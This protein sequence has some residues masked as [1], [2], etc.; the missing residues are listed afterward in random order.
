MQI[1]WENPLEK[2]PF[3]LMTLKLTR[4]ALM[5]CA[6]RGFFFPFVHIRM[7]DSAPLRPQEPR[8]RALRPRL[9]SCLSPAIGSRE[10]VLSGAS[11]PSTSDSRHK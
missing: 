8:R 1:F 2:P 6:C 9:F 4:R 11:E 10:P 7:L 5:K 3:M